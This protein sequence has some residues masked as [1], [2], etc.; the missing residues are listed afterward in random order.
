M[1]VV[2]L[3]NPG[4]SVM[5]W[6]S[7][8]GLTKGLVQKLDYFH[9]SSLSQL[10]QLSQNLSRP[11]SDSLCSLPAHMDVCSADWWLLM[12][13]VGPLSVPAVSRNST[14]LDAESQKD[15]ATETWLLFFFCWKEEKREGA[16]SLPLCSIKKQRPGG[17]FLLSSVSK[18]WCFLAVCWRHLSGLELAVTPQIPLCRNG[19]L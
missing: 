17:D 9:S 19:S 5:L 12:N 7:I 3:F 4:H 13:C 1:V 16:V 18:V 14:S 2:I 8:L 6:T 10:H 15:S 11:R